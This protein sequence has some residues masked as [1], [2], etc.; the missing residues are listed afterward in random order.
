MDGE[1]QGRVHLERLAV[2]AG[3]RR[4]RARAHLEALGGELVPVA[5]PVAAAPM[6]ARVTIAAAS[7][8]DGCR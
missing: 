2:D 1:H 3:E 7:F 8:P 5:A 6:A 4:A